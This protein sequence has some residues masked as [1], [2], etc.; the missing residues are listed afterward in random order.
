MDRKLNDRTRYG[1]PALIGLV[2]IGILL[3]LGDLH[4]R[5]SSAI[6]DAERANARL[7]DVLAEQA[8]STFEGLGRTLTAAELVRTNSSAG[9]YPMAM[10][11]RALR[12]LRSSNPLVTGIEWTDA[13]GNVAVHSFEGDLARPSLAGRPFF[14]AQR[15]GKDDR[16]LI[17]RPVRSDETGEWSTSVSRRLTNADGSFAGVMSATLD[18]SYFAPVF[19]ALRPQSN[20]SV[21]LMDR[22]GVIL[23]REPFVD[24]AM[25]T[26][27]KSDSPI[28]KYLSKMDSGEI[29]AVSQIDGISRLVAFKTVPGFPLVMI[30]TSARALALDPVYEHV[31]AAAPVA[32]ALIVLVVLGGAHLLRQDRAIARQAALLQAALENMEQGLIVVDNKGA[33]PVCNRRAMELLDLPP[34]LMD[35]NPNADELIAYQTRQGEFANVPDDVKSRL[36]PRI[37]GESRNVYERKRPNGTILEIQTV[38]FANGGVVRTYTDV[39]AQRAAEAALKDSE[40]RYRLLA[41]S[42]TDM[43]FRLDLDLIRRYVSPAS[44]EILGYS[45]EELTGR[46]PVNMIHPNDAEQVEETY[47]AV[48]NGRER[49]SV[50]NRIRHRDGHWV[51]VEA[52]LR[53]VRDQDG[54]P[55]GILGALRDV[56]ARKA[57]EDEAIAA[58]KLAEQAAA[59]QGQFLATMSHELRTPL[60]SVL[61]FADIILD[62]SDLDPEVRRQ[63]GLIQTA[64]AFLLTAVND[65]LDFSKI[66][67]GKLELVSTEFSLTSLIDGSISVLRDAAS[68]KHLELTVETDRRIPPYVCG[69]ESRL[70]Q[71]LLNLL[72]NAIKFTPSGHV[73]LTVE[74]IESRSDGERLRFTVS[75]TGIGI[76]GDKLHRLFQRFSQVDGST[77]REFGGTGLGLAIC[78]RLIELMGGEIGVASNVGKGSAFWFAVTLSPA[79]G[80]DSTRVPHQGRAPIARPSRILVVEDLDVNQEIVRSMLEAAGHRVDVVSD[81]SE[82]ISAVEACRY[83]VVL[84]DI[85]MAGMDGVT[86]TKRIRSLPEPGRQVPIVAMTA[87]VLPQQVETFRAA[88]MNGHVGKPL[89]RDELL[90]AIDRAASQEMSPALLAQ[91]NPDNSAAVLNVETF[92]AVSDLLGPKKVNELLG[93]LGTRLANQFVEKPESDAQWAEIAQEAHKLTSSAGMLGFNDLSGICAE[94]EA[95]VRDDSPDLAKILAA[96]RAACQAALAEIAFRSALSETVARGA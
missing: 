26:S 54:R 39:T 4:S 75:D 68:K 35:S 22:E 16:F 91:P 42:S 1:L 88:G 12:L 82:A 58:R 52:E 62:R 25:Q 6:A 87:N 7:A 59:A 83:D 13:A 32:I 67:E 78:K 76:P 69:D 57:A 5:Y 86:A 72:N 8:S 29:E 30:V 19:K 2:T 24:I 96:A 43:I 48:L 17:D 63:V 71:V 14:E 47:L 94:L 33:L 50:T 89:R 53:L 38:P 21:V 37:H 44:Y 10:A 66:E 36:L 80:S 23:T 56:S 49:A 84:M 27:F 93:K 46:K 92:A 79:A 60:N 51:W 65:V 85:Q 81:G 77:S 3:F 28:L 9:L 64:G 41:D 45:A 31:R 40:T 73:A 11:Y 95:A 18:L 74:H 55:C 15:N 34:S 90:A 61:G 70:R 20:G